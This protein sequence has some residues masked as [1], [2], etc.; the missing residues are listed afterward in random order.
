MNV[1]K[2]VYNFI[3]GDMVILVGVIITVV[4]LALINT[5]AALATLRV[6]SGYILVI[7]ALIILTATL[8]R[9]TQGKK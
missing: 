9:E 3:V 8:Y 5:V 4:L 6:A 7:A 2:A 1:I